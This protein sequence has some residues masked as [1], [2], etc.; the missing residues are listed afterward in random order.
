MPDDELNTISTSIS[1][2]AEPLVPAAGASAVAKP[3]NLHG[4]AF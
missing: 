4:F 2:G 3:L 1:Q